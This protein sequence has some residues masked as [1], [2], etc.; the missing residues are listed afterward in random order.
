MSEVAQKKDRPVLWFFL[1]F[2]LG[3]G[4]SIFHTVMTWA[5]LLNSGNRGLSVL[6]LSLLLYLAYMALLY[7]LLRKHKATAATGLLTGAGI[8]TLLNAQC[9]ATLYINT[10]AR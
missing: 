2:L 8:I 6:L 9:A 4:L 1:G 10:H 7:L 3:F 5:F